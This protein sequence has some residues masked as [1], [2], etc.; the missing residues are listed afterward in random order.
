MD[1]LYMFSVDIWKDNAN[2]EMFLSKVGIS[3]IVIV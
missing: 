1:V 3:C 2:N